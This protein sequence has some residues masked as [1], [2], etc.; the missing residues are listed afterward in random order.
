MT[1]YS[2][3]YLGNPRYWVTGV[4][5]PE[6]VGEANFPHDPNAGVLTDPPHAGD[7]VSEPIQRENRCPLEGRDIEG[8][9]DVGEVVLDEVDLGPDATRWNP[10]SIGERG[11]DAQ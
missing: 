1:L 11:A 9:G 7:H 6:G 10:E 3:P 8:A 2:S 4:E 5:D